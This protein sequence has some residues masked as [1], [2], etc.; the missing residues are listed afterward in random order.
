VTEPAQPAQDL[1]GFTM[2][3]VDD[4]LTCTDE[5]CLIPGGPG[6][7]AQWPSFPDPARNQLARVLVVRASSVSARVGDEPDVGGHEV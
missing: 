3:G 7:E 1:S 4:T 2:L 5:T 6:A